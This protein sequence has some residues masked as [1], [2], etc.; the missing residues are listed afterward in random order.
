M[1]EGNNGEIFTRVTAY[2][3]WVD[4]LFENIGLGKLF[5]EP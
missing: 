5:L 2:W 4:G 3:L 1:N